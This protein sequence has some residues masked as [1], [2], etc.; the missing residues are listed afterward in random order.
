MGNADAGPGTVSSKGLEAGSLGL[1]AI[2]TLGISCVAPAYALTATMGPTIGIV[3]TQLP[4]IFIVG[5]LPMLL[6]ALGYRELNADAP[7]SGTSFTWATKAFGPYIG[8]LGGWGLVTATVIVLSNLAGIAAGSYY[9]IMHV[10]SEHV[11]ADTILTLGMMICFYYGLTAFA[12]VFYFRNTLLKSFR[13]FV[14]RGLCPFVGGSVL[15]AV[16][17]Q[18]TKDSLNPDYGSGSA[19]FGI[20]LVF[21]IGVGVISLGVILM[22]FIS[23]QK[24]EF[25]RGQTLR[26]DTPIL[27]M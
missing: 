25:F 4:A 20:G 1:V 15:F 22:L 7:D 8:W 5:F 19:I 21:V 6:V 14:L 16:F 12:C 17:L 23:W 11:L 27:R 2:V 10:I 24:P 13:N 26:R 18:T 3:G 9:S